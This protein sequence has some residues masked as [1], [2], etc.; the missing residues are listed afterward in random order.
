MLRCLDRIG[1]VC[2]L[3]WAFKALVCFKGLLQ[4]RGN[5]EFDIMFPQR[6]ACTLSREHRVRREMRRIQE[7]NPA[8]FTRDHSDIQ[9][10]GEDSWV[11]CEVQL[12]AHVLSLFNTM[13][14][15]E[16]WGLMGCS[17]R[18]CHNCFHL[19]KKVSNFQTESSHGK[20]YARWPIPNDLWRNPTIHR[21]LRELSNSLGRRFS[22]FE[23][24]RR[25]GIRESAPLCRYDFRSELRKWEPPQEPTVSGRGFEGAEA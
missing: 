17:K 6:F 19:L 14:P 7:Q 22:R 23:V 11:H 25:E 5:I 24:R 13:D 3:R 15:E 8:L 16:M 1:E 20:I 12:L 4:R 18:P 10:T 2:E 9:V 21:A